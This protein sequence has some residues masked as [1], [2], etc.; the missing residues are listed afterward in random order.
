MTFDRLTLGDSARIPLRLPADET[1]ALYHNPISYSSGSPL[2]QHFC[3]TKLSDAPRY[4][5]QRS[6]ELNMLNLRTRP[7]QPRD[8]RKHTQ[9]LSPRRNPPENACSSRSQ[10]RRKA[11]REARSPVR[12]VA[13][14]GLG[15]GL[16]EPARN[17]PGRVANANL[18]F[19]RL[20]KTSLG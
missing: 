6:Q 7:R 8:F 16:E 19:A 17:Q 10:A 13:T 1:A 11:E 14:A 3:N 18:R 15:T 2:S 12:A 20:D 5:Y 9:V 4:E